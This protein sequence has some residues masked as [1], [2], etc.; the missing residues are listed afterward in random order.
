M[1]VKKK[2]RC[3]TCLG[4]KEVVVETDYDNNGDPITQWGKCRPC[5]GS[6]F[7]YVQEEKERV[8]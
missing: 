6:G 5:K 1:S 4:D 3:P 2:K 8:A 7:I